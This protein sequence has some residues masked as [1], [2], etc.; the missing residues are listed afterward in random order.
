MQSVETFAGVDKTPDGVTDIVELLLSGGTNQAFEFGFMRVRRPTVTPDSVV[1]GVEWH[2]P[3]NSQDNEQLI[4][5]R[6]IGQ[7]ISL[8]TALQAAWKKQQAAVSK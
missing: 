7:F 3:G 2:A 4:N 1:I 8:F 6:D 5:L